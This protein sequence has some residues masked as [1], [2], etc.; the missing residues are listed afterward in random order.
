MEKV[1]AKINGAYNNIEYGLCHYALRDLTGAPVEEMYDESDIEKVWSVVKGGIDNQYLLTCGTE[2][3][4]EDEDENADGVVRGHSYTILDACEVK[5]LSRNTTERLVK[6]RNPWV[7]FE[8]KGDWS[9][10]SDLWS[11]DLREKLNYQ[12]EAN[13]GIFYMNIQDYNKYFPVTYVCKYRPNNYY[14]SINFQHGLNNYNVIRLYVPENTEITVSLNQRD[15][16]YFKG[17]NH[18]EYNYSYARLLV[19]EIT[20]DGLEYCT[21]NS[22]GYLRNLQA[23]HTFKAGTYLITAEVNW[24]QDFHKVFNVSFYSEKM[25]GIEGLEYADLLQIQRNIVISAI[26][27]LENSKTVTSY[28]K[29]GDA[30]I[31]KTVDCIHGLFYFYYENNSKKKQRLVETIKFSQVNNLRILAP[32]SDDF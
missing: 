5:P 17:T 31:Q 28:G 4:D 23:T 8:W 6:I 30:K 11:N 20:K 25:I 3:G 1:Y 24:N 13:D 10:K 15:K 26:G 12:P 9:D 32:Y 18:P 14:Y 2:L 22:S 16:R 27:K 19:A 29:Y 7:N 21:G